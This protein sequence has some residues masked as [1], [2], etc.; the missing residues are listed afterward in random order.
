MGLL[1]NRVSMPRTDS[2]TRAVALPGQ[3]DW[4]EVDPSNNE[5]VYGTVKAELMERVRA[6]HTSQ[7]A[8]VALFKSSVFGAAENQQVLSHLLLQSFD[9]AHLHLRRSGRNVHPSRA[10]RLRKP[11]RR[12]CSQRRHAALRNNGGG[13]RC[14]H[15]AQ[16][17]DAHA[18]AG[19]PFLQL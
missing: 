1:G 7:A 6:A 13:P 12:R 9:A 2:V 18:K 17:W 8:L 15:P 16:H 10:G 3:E 4:S 19:D 5:T 14:A 11:H